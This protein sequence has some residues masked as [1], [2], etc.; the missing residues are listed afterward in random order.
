MEKDAFDTTVEN[1]NKES[2]G[3]EDS[4]PAVV[5]DDYEDIDEEEFNEE[6]EERQ[7]PMLFIFSVTIGFLF[8]GGL[9]FDAMEPSDEWTFGSSLY[10]SSISFFTIG[11]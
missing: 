1:D 9:I 6:S 10:F 8:L 2:I 7:I 3:P 5:E 4:V 11:D